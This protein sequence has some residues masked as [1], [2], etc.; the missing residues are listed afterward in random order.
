MKNNPTK[1]IIHTSDV[2]YETIRD[3][4]NSINSYHKSEGFPVSRAGIFVGYHS[5]I[6]GGRNYKCKEDD[7]EGAHT[8][9]VFN[10]ISMNLQSLGVCIGF[11]GD[12]EYP[13]VEHFKLLKEQVFTWQDKYGI[14]DEEVYF[15]RDWN[16]AKTCPGSLLTKEWKK[17]LLLREAKAKP[18]SQCE[19]QEAIIAERDKEIS[20]L[21]KLIASLKEWVAGW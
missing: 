21:K 17:A 9:N 8:N 13:T 10:G 5:L 3:Q 2:P 18:G 15:H 16:K 7:E 1:I 11:D 12:I 19:K 20:A 14:P 4:F 6:T